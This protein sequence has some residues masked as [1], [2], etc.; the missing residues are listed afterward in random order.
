MTQAHPTPKTK[1]SLFYAAVVV[2]TYTILVLLVY[3]SWYTYRTKQN[4]EELIEKKK[5]D[6]AV[7]AAAGV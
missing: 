2:Y 1:N 5:K 4:S 6:S 3:I 7:V